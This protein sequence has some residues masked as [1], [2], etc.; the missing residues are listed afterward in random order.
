MN[1]HTV[2]QG[3]HVSKYL[4]PMVQPE[5]EVWLTA[6]KPLVQEIKTFLNGYLV[7]MAGQSTKKTT[8]RGMEQAHYN[9]NEKRAFFTIPQA[10]RINMTFL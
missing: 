8:S 7:A 3:L 10:I 9:D 4:S 2:K 6:I 1:D 5:G